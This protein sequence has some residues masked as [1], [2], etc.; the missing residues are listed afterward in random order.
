[1]SI[2]DTITRTLHERQEAATVA[3][4]S[5]V[6][7]IA[8]DSSDANPEA[9]EKCLRDSQKTIED[10]Q[11]DVRLAKRRNEWRETIAQADNAKKQ[12]DLARKEIAAADDELEQARQARHA[13][14]RPLSAQISEAED[15]INAAVSAKAE[16]RNTMFDEDKQRLAQL[17]SQVQRLHRALTQA[18]A[19]LASIRSRREVDR[20][21]IQA[22]KGWIKD[23][24]EP[25]KLASSTMQIS[26]AEERVTN[27]QRALDAAID[28]R[29]AFT[30]EA[31]A[32]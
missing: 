26:A 6:T 17:D 23:G 12:I 20:D 21:A 14:V 27:A 4:R 18:Q 2:L 31:M 5:I 30:A 22:A 15:Q 29:D 11:S 24:I 28:E 7:A 16:L 13:K 19:Q 8:R 32:R 10:L 9:I 3:Y 25:T 1:M